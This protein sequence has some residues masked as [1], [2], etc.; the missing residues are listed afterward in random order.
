MVFWVF[1]VLLFFLFSRG[2]FGFFGFL[3]V[4]LF[5]PFLQVCPFCC[6][7]CF[8]TG[9][10]FVMERVYTKSGPKVKHLGI[11]KFVSN[12]SSIFPLPTSSWLFFLLF[13]CMHMVWTEH[14][15]L[16]KDGHRLHCLVRLLCCASGP[17]TTWWS[18]GGLV[19]SHWCW[20][21]SFWTSWMSVHKLRCWCLSAGDLAL[22]L[23]LTA[24]MLA[25]NGTRC[26]RWGVHWA[27]Q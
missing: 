8:H 1:L 3:E 15:S 22:Q 12:S 25:F 14:V 6:Q 11:P 7:D 18:D 17:G 23:Y 16:Q 4:F 21:H 24:K 13:C 19:S 20:R 2:F 26:R 27:D 9:F 5:S 10:A